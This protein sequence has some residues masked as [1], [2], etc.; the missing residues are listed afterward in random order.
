MNAINI[1]SW[2]HAPTYAPTTWFIIIACTYIMHTLS[3][4]VI[5]YLEILSCAES[6]VP[7]SLTSPPRTPLSS[8]IYSR[9]LPTVC[10]TPVRNFPVRYYCSHYF[11]ARYHRVHTVLL[12]VLI[13][14]FICMY[15]I[16]YTLINFEFKLI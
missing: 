12:F 13:F 16:L 15:K 2:E 1:W 7:C 5:F 3:F 11:L 4:W 10:A 9:A 8:T 6:L 14:D